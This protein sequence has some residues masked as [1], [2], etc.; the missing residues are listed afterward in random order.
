MLST[1]STVA[2]SA[3]SMY[4]YGG[5]GRKKIS[6]RPI[7]NTA[8]AA[9]RHQ[10]VRLQFTRLRGTVA[11]HTPPPPPSSTT[12]NPEPLFRETPPPLPKRRPL[13]LRF[14]KTALL[15]LLFLTAGFTMAAAPALETAEQFI[16]PPTDAETLKLYIPDNDEHIAIEE[17][18]WNHPFTKS[19]IADPK[20]SA[21]R[22]HLKIPAN[23]RAQNLTGGT[24]LGQDKIAVPPLQFTTNDGSEFVSI[25]YLGPAL[26]GHPGIVHGGLLATLLD[27][28]LAR[29]CFPALPNKVGVTAS[30][31]IDYRRP[32]MASQIV[33]L[34]AE[35]TKVEGRK[36]WV[37]GRL[38]TLGDE[39]KGE[40][41]VVLVE[42]EA[43]FIEP[44]QAATMMK[45]YSSQ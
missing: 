32:C 4:R 40:S 23:L 44:K 14:S 35:T 30:L 22:P 38:E 13:W 29:C 39:E 20:F 2:K 27:E 17:A 6:P 37:K 25:Q 7:I 42:A 33:V 28:G 26:C 21:S 9:F 43:L 8:P 41:P 34:R 19:L 1:R 16:H 36:A 15:S 11:N 10:I 3:F 5:L 12:P 31:K 24:L 18:I 45:V